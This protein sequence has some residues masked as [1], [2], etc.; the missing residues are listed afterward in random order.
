[1]SVFKP[2]MD[3]NGGTQAWELRCVERIEK[4]ISVRNC[5]NASC[6]LTV[7]S[8]R[9]GSTWHLTFC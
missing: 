6:I 7:S 3:E 2:V 4:E 1:M 8:V 9:S 5:G